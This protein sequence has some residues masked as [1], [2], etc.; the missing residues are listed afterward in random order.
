LNPVRQ[1][2][3]LSALP[4]AHSYQ[5]PARSVSEAS[6]FPRLPFGLVRTR[7]FGGSRTHR[8]DFHRV[9]CKTATLQTP[10]LSAEG[11]GVEPAR[12][13]EGSAAFQAAPVAKSGGP[14]VQ[15]SRVDSNHRSSP[16]QGAVLATERRDDSFTVCAPRRSRTRNGRSG[17]K[18][19]F[20]CSLAEHPV[21]ANGDTCGSWHR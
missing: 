3:R 2:W 15:S 11:A 10:S 4:G 12:P 5:I 21:Q 19:E 6:R 9:A 20:T 8:C 17:R 16:R 18:N 13:C 14:S 1:L 7:V